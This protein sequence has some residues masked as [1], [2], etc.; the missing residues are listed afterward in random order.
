[1]RP[2]LILL[3]A[4]LTITASAQLDL[5]LLAHWTFTAGGVVD[6][7]GNGHDAVVVGAVTGTAD[8][9]GGSGCAKLFTGVSDHLAVPF[10]PA[11]DL[12]AEDAFTISIWYQ[13]GSAEAGDHESLFARRDPSGSPFTTDYSVNLY[14]L[15]RVL[16]SVGEQGYL[17]SPVEP[18]IPDAQ[19][20]HVAYI[21]SNGIQ[22]IWQD[23]VLQ[24]WDSTQQAFISQST[25]GLVLG[26]YFEGAM[27]DIRFYDR[28][29]N[30]AEVALLYQ[31]PAVCGS[32]G[33]AEL[34]I[35][36]VALSPNP[37][38]D[39]LTVYLPGAAFAQPRLLELFDATGRSV[40]RLQ[41]TGN[42]VTLPL[43][44]LPSGLYLLRIGSGASALV[45]RVL[46]Q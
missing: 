46:V 29:L 12:A 40:Q 31:E 5:G 10:S 25:E 22:Q 36:G 1:M 24:A 35:S 20:H 6:V 18:P 7:S 33:M 3:L 26:Q 43:A 17:W 39:L 13:G 2:F 21:Y 42:T 34:G 16:G 38:R 9:A 11:F 30:P 44:D 8:R 45:E 19:W 23:N 32:T 4:S 15:N 14:D 37:A 41:A 28:A 27:D